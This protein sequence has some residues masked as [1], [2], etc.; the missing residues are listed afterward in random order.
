MNNFNYGARDLFDDVMDGARRSNVAPV[1]VGRWTALRRM[2]CRVPV[3]LMQGV[4]PHL[5]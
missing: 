1:D 3:R 4:W 2:L 5:P